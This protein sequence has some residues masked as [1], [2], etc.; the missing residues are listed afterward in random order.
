MSPTY[1]LIHGS[2]HTGEAWE[3][4]VAALAEHGIT[5]VHTPTIAGHGPGVPKDVTHN[6][7]VQS[8]VDYIVERDLTDFVLLGHSYGGTIVSRVYE[9]VPD[10]I[11]R[12][13]YLNAF[14]L[15]P[16]G[17][18]NDETPPQD[19]APFEMLA[20]ASDDDTI[21]MPFPVWRERFIGDAD[22]ELAQQTYATL[23]PEP[24][25][26]WRDRLPLDRFY[27][28]IDRV[29]RSYINCTEDIAIPQGEQWSWH[30]RMSQRLGSP[31]LVQLH[32]SHETLFSNPVLL[33]EKIVEAGRD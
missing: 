22:F 4:V 28:T 27:A 11:R 18:L 3:G 9:E 26:P 31:R 6:D 5:D 2:W 30:P 20:A 29:G 32:G 15:A 24:A 1:V 16:N 10:R 25:Q 8:I 23:S 21:T 19:R 17:C 12:L 33:A 13:V 14:V 7:C